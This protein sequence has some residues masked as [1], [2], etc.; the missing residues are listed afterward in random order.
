MQLE[1]KQLSRKEK[2]RTNHTQTEVYEMSSS[3]WLGLKSKGLGCGSGLVPGSQAPALPALVL[4]VTTPL[5][6]QRGW[7]TK[8]GREREAAFGA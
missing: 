7:D 4:N 8:T 5:E 3:P 1:S 6:G 2:H